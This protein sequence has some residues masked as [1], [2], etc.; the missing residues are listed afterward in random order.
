M[1]A[2]ALK[3]LAEEY[4]ETRNECIAVLT[5]QLEQ[6]EKQ[7]PVFNAM[8]IGALT[9]LEAAESASMKTWRRSFKF[10]TTQLR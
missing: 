4:P 2:D 8:L 10:S 9:D 6:A 5:R 1:A 3:A 7:D